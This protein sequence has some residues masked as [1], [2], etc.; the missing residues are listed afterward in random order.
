MK[1][2]FVENNENNI[3]PKTH[4]LVRLAELSGVELSD[5]QKF[6]LDKINDFNIQTHYPDYKLDFYKQCDAEYSGSITNR[7]AKAKTFDW[8]YRIHW[9]K[10]YYNSV[11]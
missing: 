10:T 8:I 7:V 5:E 3:A 6:Y 11:D 9:I 1:A 4:N 2:L